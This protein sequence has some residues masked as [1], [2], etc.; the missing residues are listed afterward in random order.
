MTAAS[1]HT[2]RVDPLTGILDSISADRMMADVEAIAAH[3]RLSGTAEEALAFDYIESELAAV[4]LTPQRMASDALVSLP[5]AASVVLLGETEQDFACITHSMAASTPPEGVTGEVRHLGKGGASDFES[6]DLAGRIVLV[7][8][9]VNPAIADRAAQ[10][11]CAAVV[12]VGDE[13]LHQGI[14]SS[15]YG[16]PTSKTIGD[17]PNCVAVSITAADG[18]VVKQRL[19]SGPVS[20]RVT[21]SVDTKWTDLP[22]VV[23]DLAAPTGDGTYAFFGVHVDS[24]DV[25]ASDNGAGN[26]ILLELARVFTAHREELQRGV[27]FLFWSGHSHGRYAGSCWYVDNFWQDIYDRAVIAMSIDSPGT[28]GADKLGGAKV[29]DE[30]VAVGTEVAERVVGHEVPAPSRPPGGEQP[31]WRVGVASMNPVR[32]R[33]TPGSAT[34]LSFSPTSPYWHHSV[35]D[36]VDKVDPGVLLDDAKIYG[37]GLAR[38]V[39]DEVLPLDYATTARAVAD[40]LRELPPIVDLTDVAKAADQ[41]AESVDA[42]IHSKPADINNRIRLLGRALIPALYTAGGQF[43]PDP[44][45]Q[46]GFI[47]GLAAARKA[48]ELETTDPLFHALRT[49]L[50]REVNRIRFALISANDIANGR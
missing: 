38:F 13:R 35:E 5:G 10:A 39:T 43:E 31:L 36:T 6:D 40:H 7:D 49:E 12:F 14:I 42:M 18:D 29:M 28:K 1:P 22:L 17:L 34:S 47:P 16:S 30:A 24:W 46:K 2:A 50:V 44:A 4:G 33:H 48:S 23:A 45:I 37:A 8:S 21:A 19:A 25:G 3:V 15:L 27:R 26:A 9:L 11:G 20:L 41:L 32:W